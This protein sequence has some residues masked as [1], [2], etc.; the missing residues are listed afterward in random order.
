[1]KNF[2]QG[3]LFISLMLGFILGASALAE[4]LATIITM[5]MIMTVC[6]IFLGIALVY[7]FTHWGEI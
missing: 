3:I 4:F 6:Y 2:L 7:L 1:M 5:E